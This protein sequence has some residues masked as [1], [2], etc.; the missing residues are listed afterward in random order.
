MAPKT[1]RMLGEFHVAKSIRG[2]E[3][4]QGARARAATVR[5]PGNSWHRALC[6]GRI[7]YAFIIKLCIRST[8]YAINVPD[9]DLM[10]HSPWS[11]AG[12]S[13]NLSTNTVN[14]DL[15]VI[16]IYCLDEA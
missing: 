15:P 6:M 13:S 5:K 1:V 16:P 12:L 3:R 9:D 8:G 2:G 14:E 4:V 7:G 11:L 10:I